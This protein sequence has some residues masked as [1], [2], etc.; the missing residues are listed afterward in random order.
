MQTHHSKDIDIYLQ[1][2]KNSRK[3]RNTSTPEFIAST[4]DFIAS[5]FAQKNFRLFLLCV[6]FISAF[7]QFTKVNKYKV[8]AYETPANHTLQKEVT[9]ILPYSRYAVLEEQTGPIYLINKP[10]QLYSN[11]LPIS[12]VAQLFITLNC[13]KYSHFIIRRIHPLVNTKRLHDVV[14]IHQ[15]H[16]TL[17]EIIYSL[18]TNKVYRILWAIIHKRRLKIQTA[19]HNYKKRQNASGH[20]QRRSLPQYSYTLSDYRWNTENDDTCVVTPVAWRNT[21]RTNVLYTL[22]QLHSYLPWVGTHTFAQDQTGHAYQHM[23]DSHAYQH[24]KDGHAHQ[25]YLF[26]GPSGT[27]KT[28][29]SQAIAGSAKVNLFCTTLSELQSSSLTSGC[30]H[31]RRLFQQAKMYAPSVIVLE[32]LELIGEIR[33]ESTTHLDIQLFTQLLVALTPNHHQTE[34]ISAYKDTKYKGAY[35]GYT[36]SDYS[37]IIPWYY[38]KNHHTIHRYDLKTI[39][40]KEA[41]SVLTRI[42]KLKSSFNRNAGISVEPN[43]LIGTTDKIEKL[44]PALIRPGRFNRIIYFS[45]PNTKDRIRLLHH[46]SMQTADGHN[47]QTKAKLEYPAQWCNLATQ[48]ASLS[49]YF[50]KKTKGYTQAHIH[51][52]V[53]E[54]K[55]HYIRKLHAGT[56]FH[57]FIINTADGYGRKS[58][59]L[60]KVYISSVRSLT[61]VIHKIAKY[62]ILLFCIIVLFTNCVH[63]LYKLPSRL[64]LWL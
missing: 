53:N 11:V 28:L 33:K 63:R 25:N 41:Q 40:R 16:H 44:D 9:H 32:N 18:N 4:P 13:R 6:I 30:A 35:P 34:H 51:T 15:V 22:R 10:L 54:S 45:R 37:A 12:M 29:V 8:Q 48:C 52:M 38:Y 1:I 61:I 47:L 46:Y 26:V 64:Q 20:V 43:I 21:L 14:A 56:P 19:L 5:I 50:A 62:N 59:V 3:K 49:T 7:I 58:S 57:S 42:K 23:E 55:L 27:G 24:M 39:L 31:L 2:L 17:H 60:N 36:I